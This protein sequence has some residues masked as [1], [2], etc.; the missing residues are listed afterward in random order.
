MLTDD[1]GTRPT[2]A[3]A[4]WRARLS[5]LLD[6]R[7]REVLAIVAIGAVVLAIAL[8]SFLRARPVPIAAEPVPAPPSATPA[9]TGERIYVHVAGA[10]RSPGVYE[11]T[12]GARVVEALRA[13]GGPARGADTDAVN[14]ARPLVDGE[15]IWIP[16]RGEAPPAGAGG[17]GGGPPGGGG[18][19][20]ARD[21]K[22][23]INLAS[24]SELEELPGI[25]PVLAERI[26]EYREQH[27]PFRTVRDLLKVSGIGE[28]KFSSLESHITV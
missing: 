18:A 14:L 13:A 22:V 28:K 11:L 8:V 24:A 3:P 25:G 9:H 17:G 5:A 7:P 15:Q 6:F 20:A 10:V 21:G 27:G 23:N 26:V 1:P 4:P 19:G 2:G 12:A 16:K